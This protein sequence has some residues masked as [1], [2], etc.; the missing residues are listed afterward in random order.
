MNRFRMIKV[1]LMAE[2]NLQAE[3]LRV[4]S[5]RS[6]EDVMLFEIVSFLVV[7]MEQCTEITITVFLVRVGVRKFPRF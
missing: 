4:F 7:L 3:L 6:H 1:M 2:V 5:G